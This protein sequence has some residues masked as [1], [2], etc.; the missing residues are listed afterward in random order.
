MDFVEEIALYVQKYASSYGIMVHSPII[1]QAILE[2][3]KGTS[4]LALNA[5]NCLG[6]K[7]NPNK[8]KRC[9]TSI[10]YYV[11]NGSEQ[12]PDGSYTEST[13][14]WQKFKNFEDCVIG[15]FDFISA[16]WYSALKG[17]TNPKTYL[18]EIKKAGYA[19]S[20]NYVENLMNV[21]DEYNLRRFDNVKEEEKMVFN[22]HAGHNPDGKVACGAI[23]FV[24]ESTENRNVKNEVVR[25][26]RALGHTVY[27]CTVEDGKS[28]GNVLSSI[29]NK[30]NAH[31]VDL[32]VS[33]HFNAGAKD[34]V[35]NGKTTG[36]EVFVYNTNSKAKPYAENVC[37]SIEKLGFKNR[38]VKYST[39]LYVLR[40]TTAPAMLI[41]CCF[42]D[43]KDDV[44]LYDYKSMA[45]AIVYG[46]VGE[47]YKD[48][49]VE[50]DDVD[51]LMPDAETE[52]NDGN[53]LYRVQVGAYS[54]KEN[55]V[56]IAQKLLKDGY[57]SVIV[58]S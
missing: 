40:K 39:R 24:K 9:P 6:I 36:T 7:Y 35:G 29:V 15:Y 17:I 47:N 27:D 11:K 46:L 2:S 56:A 12:N 58:K 19:T 20:I 3:A 33:I 50:K 49:V 18:E 22:I 41:E 57:N 28:A 42:V 14:L 1:A 34:S 44:A 48:E 37:K 25:Q 5:K 13:M 52:F 54:K 30:C 45:D 53:V 23:G 4:E 10:G 26:L 31:E 55:A 8:P 21:I 16:P 51:S 43:D 32:D 38:G